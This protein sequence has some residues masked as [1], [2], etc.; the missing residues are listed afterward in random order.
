MLKI[1]YGVFE[2]NSSST[3]SIS[4][5]P[6]LAPAGIDLTADELWMLNTLEGAGKALLDCSLIP[7]D[8]GILEI[9]DVNTMEFGWE[10][11]TYS[12]ASTKAMYCYIDQYLNKDKVKMLEEVLMEQTLARS[13][14]F[15][16][17]PEADCDSPMYGYIDHQSI[18][19]SE[20]AFA[21][22]ETL[23]N[24]IFNKH[25]ELGTDNDNRGY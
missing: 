16:Y 4:I 14:R 12:D 18:G 10:E 17:N 25:S 15:H 7:R 20:P 2:T 11:R 1:R 6:G 8:D 22:K 9:K 24:F 5:A 19:T 23:R 21:N 13:V 3:H